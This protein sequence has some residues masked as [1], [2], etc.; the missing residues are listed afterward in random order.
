MKNIVAIGILF[1]TFNAFSQRV[2][3]KAVG[4][5]NE[6]KV[7]D[8]IEVKLIKSDENR[9]VVKGNK[10]DDL[11]VINKNGV[12]KIRMQLD[13]K[14][15]GEDTFV[16][17]HFTDLDLIDGNEGA[18]INLAETLEQSKI[19]LKTQEGAKIT[20]KLDVENVVV[21][22]V[23]GGIV[24]VTG[25]TKFEEV[26]LNTGGVF[27][28]KDLKSEMANIKITAAGEANINT[29]EKVDINIRIGGDV[30]VYGNP[31]EINQ[32][33]FAGGRVKIIK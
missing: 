4:D 20:A 9:V 26:V 28:G 10:A 8:L 19:E 14:F 23:T 15:S 27:L 22:A 32:N 3:D 16:E 31:K 29:S 18:K 21:R 30:K 5:F 33:T 17:V 24:E 12:L 11:Q 1:L 25:K 7:Y 13:K 2:V 6:I